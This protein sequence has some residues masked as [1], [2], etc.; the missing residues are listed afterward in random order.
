MGADNGAD[1]TALP[2]PIQRYPNTRI[3]YIRVHLISQYNSPKQPFA[4]MI[5]LFKR[6]YDEDVR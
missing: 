6:S 4:S 1:D 2:I 5:S 3:Y